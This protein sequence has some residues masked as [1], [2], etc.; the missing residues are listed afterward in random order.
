VWRE[1]RPSAKLHAARLRALKTLAGA[2]ADQLAFELGDTAE[3]GQ[4]QPTIKRT[5]KVFGEEMTVRRLSDCAASVME[6]D[7]PP[8]VGAPFHLH[9]N[10]DE[11]CWVIK[12]TFRIW[13]AGKEFDLGPGGFI[14]LPCDE[15]YT[16]KNI[17]TGE[18]RIVT[19][20]VPAGFE[21][22]FEEIVDE[23]RRGH[24]QNK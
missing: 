7:V 11:I 4:H 18:G 14:W 19:V 23:G 12:G 9:K 3:H 16:F 15:V 8:G 24:G 22:F 17:G 6:E 13:R 20:V 21:R 2:G 5:L 10:E 1:L